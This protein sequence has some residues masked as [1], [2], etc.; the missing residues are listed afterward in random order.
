[1]SRVLVFFFF[2]K[3]NLI[4]IG[5]P[6][7]CG[8]NRAARTRGTSTGGGAAV[9]GA[10]APP[11]AWPALCGRGVHPAVH[12]PSSSHLGIPVKNQTQNKGTHDLK[13]TRL[14]AI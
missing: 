4:A 11:R 12:I 1:M 14:T 9:R 5:P 6:S 8:P 3:Q 10:P 7:V 13:K 2:K